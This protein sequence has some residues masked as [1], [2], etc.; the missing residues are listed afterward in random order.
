MS[1]LLPNCD[2]CGGEQDELGA[3]LYGPPL[4]ILRMTEK[5]KPTMRVQKYHLCVNCFIIIRNLVVAC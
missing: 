4:K 5:E 2:K 3:V 1:A